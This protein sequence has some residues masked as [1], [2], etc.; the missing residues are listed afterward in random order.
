ME[1][2]QSYIIGEESTLPKIEKCLR[3]MRWKE[4]ALFVLHPF[5]AYGDEGNE[6]LGPSDALTTFEPAFVSLTP[7][8][9]LGIPPKC[10]IHY[11]IELL[12]FDVPTSP[13]SCQ[14]FAETFPEAFRRKEEGN[15]FFK[16]KLYDLAT[17][18]YTKSQLFLECVERDRL[19]DEQRAQIDQ[20]KLHCSLNLAFVTLRNREF[21]KTLIH[22]KAALDIDPQNMKALY[23]RGLVYP[24]NRDASTRLLP[25]I[26]HSN[27]PLTYQ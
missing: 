18:K 12:G 26:D 22:C 2:K 5:Y 4:V 6:S 27:F 17:A 19:T 10:T 9:I 1:D 21:E 20:V 15:A 25:F 23:R 16:K 24:L 13:F 11:T 7:R 8:L 14:T 3:S